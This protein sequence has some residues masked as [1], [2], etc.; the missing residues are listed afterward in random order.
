M[1]MRIS[2]ENQCCQTLPNSKVD[3]KVSSIRPL[4]CNQVIGIRVY[5]SICPSVTHSSQNP[6]TVL[7]MKLEA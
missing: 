4:P 1:G 7:S 2:I 6:L 3:K 5:P